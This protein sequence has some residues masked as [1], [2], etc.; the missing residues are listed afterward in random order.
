MPGP[1]LE[2]HLGEA[3]GLFCLL[4]IPVRKELLDLAP[5]L[6]AVGSHGDA[7][8]DANTPIAPGQAV[9]GRGCLPPCIALSFLPT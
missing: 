9:V 6:R 7:G 1:E 8:G 4:T 5:R 2:A 3:E